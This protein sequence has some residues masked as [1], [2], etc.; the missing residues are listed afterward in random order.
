VT[1]V[2]GGRRVAGFVVRV[3]STQQRKRIR[4]HLKARARM[5]ALC[6][7]PLALWRWSKARAQKEWGMELATHSTKIC[8]RNLG[9]AS[10]R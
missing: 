2:A 3:L 10:R 9:S 8:R 7:A 6:D 5:V 4:S 1:V